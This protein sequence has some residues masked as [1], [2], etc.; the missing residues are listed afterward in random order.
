MWDLW[1]TKWCWDRF[2]SKCFGFPLSIPFHHRSTLVF[3][4]VFLSPDKGMK[5][6]ETFQEAV[7]FRT[8]GSIV[9]KRI[10]SFLHSKWLL[11]FCWAPYKYLKQL[12][13]LSAQFNY[14]HPYQL[15]SRIRTDILILLASCQQTWMTYTIAVCTVKN[16]WWMTE[17][18]SET[19]RVLF[20][21]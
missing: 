20:Q 3:I 5:R 18:L 1:R 10:F 9:Y 12:Q 11:K 13:S 14:F 8:S 15:V 6:L 7:L 19:C 4:Y 16:S 21:K 2:F 17:E